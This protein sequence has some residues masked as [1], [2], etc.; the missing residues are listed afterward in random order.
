MEPLHPLSQ[1]VGALMR[2][3]ETITSADSLARAARLLRESSAE[4]LPVLEDDKMIGVVDDPSLAKALESGLGA[5]SSAS[6]VM[7]SGFPTIPAFASG[8]EALRRL[9][10]TDARTLAVVD[11]QGHFLGILS[12]SDLFPRYEVPPTLPVVGG[13]ATPFGV[14]LTAGGVQAGAGHIAL[15]CTGMQLGLLMILSAIGADWMAAHASPFFGF[16]VTPDWIPNM[17]AIGLFMVGMRVSPLAGTHASEHKVVHALEYGEPLELEV[18]KRM[19]RVHPRCGTNIAV[20]L[21]L[22]TGITGLPWIPREISALAGVLVAFFFWRPLGGLAQFWITTK[23]PTDRQL[24]NG[25]AAGKELIR[26]VQARQRVK[27]TF[28]RWIVCSGLLHVML[29]STLV[30]LLAEGIARLFGTST[31]MAVY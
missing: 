30:M 23:P 5:L 24:L 17:L 22:F 25:I 11:S 29:G 15:I 31:G 3:V 7:E 6:T 12:A 2:H 21:S 27:R 13:M 16:K 20:G 9:S 1:P 18:V 8:S 28:G 26:K 10:D 14:Y 19:S 4:V